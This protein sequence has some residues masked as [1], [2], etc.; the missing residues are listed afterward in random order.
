MKSWASS[1]TGTNRREHL[2]RVGL[3]VVLLGAVLWALPVRRPGEEGGHHADQAPVL[4][5]WERAGVT[6]FKEGQ[7]APRLSLPRLDGGRAA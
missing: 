4:D 1:L 2:T 6:E 5:P 3:A 7:R